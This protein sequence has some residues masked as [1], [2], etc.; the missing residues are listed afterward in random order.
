M[1]GGQPG[2]TRNSPSEPH[3]VGG[4]IL[5]L[6]A[7]F[8]LSPNFL[9]M[10]NAFVDLRDL[11]RVEL[12]ENVAQFDHPFLAGRSRIHGDAIGVGD[13]DLSLAQRPDCQTIPFEKLNR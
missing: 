1:I 13:L 10:S 2:S 12:K 4:A 3:N 11:L 6:H 7:L 9:K 8:P 5:W